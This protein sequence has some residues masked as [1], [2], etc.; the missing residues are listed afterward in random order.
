VYDAPV[1]AASRRSALLGL[2]AATALA[3]GCAVPGSRRHDPAVASARPEQDP[4]SRGTVQGQHLP[5]S[6]AE[7]VV[8][9]TGS[10]VFGDPAARR[11]VSPV[12]TPEQEEEVRRAFAGGDRKRQAPPPPEAEAR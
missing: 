2:L 9:G 12:L 1:P 11:E 5:L 6:E 10:D 7:Q 8:V 4:A 3:A